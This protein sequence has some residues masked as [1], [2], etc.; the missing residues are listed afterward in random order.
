MKISYMKFFFL[1]YSFLGNGI[2]W[3]MAHA[4]RYGA[5]LW[6]RKNQYSSHW[7]VSLTKMP[8]PLSLDTYDT[9]APGAPCFPRRR[10]PSTTALVKRLNILHSTTLHYSF[11]QMMKSEDS[12]DSVESGREVG[13]RETIFFLFFFFLKSTSWVF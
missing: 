13:E 8:L 7:G 2:H 12:V 6:K 9:E 3:E 11:L 1:T 10:L 4:S 5:C